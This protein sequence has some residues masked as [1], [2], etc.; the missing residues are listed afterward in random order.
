[1][2]NRKLSLGIAVGLSALMVGCAG[3]PPENQMVTEAEFAYSKIENDPNVA[4]SG[5]SE[6]R[7]ARNEL[8]RAQA[9]LAENASEEEIE[10]VA[11]LAKRHAE[12]AYEMG[13]RARLQQEIDSA[14]ERREQLVLE[15]RTSE[16]QSAQAEA[17]RLREQLLAMEAKET[18]R[19]MVLTLGDVLF[20][21]NQ[22]DLKPS[23]QR[24]IQELTEFMNEYPGRRVRVE[25]YTDSTGA[26]DYNQGLSER[27]AMSVK[28]ALTENGV[29]SS[30]IDVVG[31]GEA[32]PKASN[33]TS[34]GRQ[35][36][37]RV[38]IVISD[39]EGNIQ[40]R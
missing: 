9:L 15:M 7:S 12:I 32:Y 36:N 28:A 14:E 39:E 26:E 35:Q 18:D 33:D 1:M 17:R 23:A 11:Y 38:E 16:A 13:E 29:S 4:R 8:D 24:T 40:S 30:R 34:S 6:L 22:A 3:S 25:G 2:I 20:D 10:H 19:G 37:R 21:L 27:R 5:P 31:Y